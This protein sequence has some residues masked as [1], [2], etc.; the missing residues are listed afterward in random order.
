MSVLLKAV[1]KLRKA[2]VQV[3][4]TAPPNISLEESR[5][6]WL[7]IFVKRNN[8][9]LPEALVTRQKK[10]RPGGRHFLKAMMYC[11]LR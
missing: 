2:G 4:E 6:L 5:Q 1:N 8:L 9:P 3:D 10:C 11:W 7:S